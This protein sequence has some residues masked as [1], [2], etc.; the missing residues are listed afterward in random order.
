MNACEMLDAWIRPCPGLNQK[1]WRFKCLSTVVAEH[2][3][4]TFVSPFFMCFMVPTM[5][6]AKQNISANISLAYQEE[7]KKK[8]TP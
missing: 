1:G 4:D 2:A 6:K 3:R 7:K 5:L 8:I